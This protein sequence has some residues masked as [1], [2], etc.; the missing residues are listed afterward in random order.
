MI[1]RFDPTAILGML[2]GLTNQ[3]QPILIYQG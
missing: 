1:A 3:M 2:A